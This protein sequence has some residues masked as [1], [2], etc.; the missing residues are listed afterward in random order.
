M[1]FLYD[2]SCVQM[3][4]YTYIRA[5]YMNSMKSVTPLEQPE[6]M[7]E[8]ISWNSR[9]HDGKLISNLVNKMN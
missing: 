9:P 3:D 4:K 2:E 7:Q 6:E 5:F 1:V 8:K